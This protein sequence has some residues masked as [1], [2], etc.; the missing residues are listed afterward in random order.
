MSK[1]WTYKVLTIKPRLIT[2]KPEAIESAL[3]QLGQQGWEL[4]ALNMIGTTA[5]AYLKKE[6]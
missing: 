6:L 3:N 4:V 2:V 5:T 1:R